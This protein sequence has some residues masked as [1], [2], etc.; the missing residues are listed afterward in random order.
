V[1]RGAKWWPK[2]RHRR[3]RVS[4]R[5]PVL[6]LSSDEE[7]HR[8]LPVVE[9]LSGEFGSRS[10]RPSIGRTRRTGAG[11]LV[12]RCLVEPG[13]GC[14]RTWRGF[15]AMHRR[16]MPTTCSSIHI[17]TRCRESGDI[18]RDAS[19]RPCS[20]RH[21]GLHRPRDRFGKSVRHNSAPCRAP[22]LVATGVPV[23]L[24]EPQ[25]IYRP[26]R[27]GGLQTAVGEVPP[28]GPMTDWRAPCHAVWAMAC[29]VACEVHDVAAT[30]QAPDCSR[31]SGMRADGQ[32][33]SSEELLLDSQDH[34]RQR[35]TWRLRA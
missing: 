4:R 5:V 10:T 24:D 16:G 31:G 22:A 20:W 8:V 3:H 28:L 1:R 32:P 15:V 11:I 14:R 33:G 25:G 27:S 2:V 12:E 18:S 23:L 26:S 17:T 9:A 6:Q 30:V 35:T 7:L 19:R 13:G 29:G 21:G 34:W